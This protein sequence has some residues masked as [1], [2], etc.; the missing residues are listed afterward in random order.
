VRSWN[1][2]SRLQRSLGRK[3]L[4]LGL[5]YDG[6]FLAIPYKHGTVAKRDGLVRDA[7]INIGLLVAF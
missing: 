7:S 3:G 4:K 1:K 2:A 5:G 6:L